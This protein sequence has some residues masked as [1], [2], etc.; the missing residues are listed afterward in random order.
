MRVL[1]QETPQFRGGGVSGRDAE[2]ARNS[3]CSHKGR[4]AMGML[5]CVC[6]CPH[7]HLAD[8]N[9]S[10]RVECAGRLKKSRCRNAERRACVRQPWR[11][12]TYRP[13]RSKTEAPGERST[14]DSTRNERAG[15]A[16][17][18]AAAKLDVLTSGA[19]LAGARACH[20]CKRRSQL[21]LG[22]T[23]V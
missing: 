13:R 3:Y 12:K 18:S 11:E 23:R 17:D 15:A 9:T 5:V 19:L 4:E 22:R 6:V 10:T 20:R 16:G 21:L 7:A 8:T 1:I 2:A 14:R